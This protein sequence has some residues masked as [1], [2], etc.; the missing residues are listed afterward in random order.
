[1]IGLSLTQYFISCIIPIFHRPS[2]SSSRNDVAFVLVSHGEMWPRKQIK[3]F[4]IYEDCHFNQSTGPSYKI[5]YCAV[6]SVVLYVCSLSEIPLSHEHVSLPA[7][8]KLRLASPFYLHPSYSLNEFE[9]WS[10][11]SDVFGAHFPFHIRN[12]SQEWQKCE[13]YHSRGFRENKDFT[14]VL[15]HDTW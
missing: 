11:S 14:T 3:H 9:F 7:I 10:L 1:M 15:R 8:T 6:T 12:P 5:I 2:R 13:H 4:T